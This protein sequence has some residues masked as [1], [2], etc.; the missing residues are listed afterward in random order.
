M[1]SGDWKGCCY[2]RSCPHRAQGGSSPHPPNHM[3]QEWGGPRGH[4]SGLAFVGSS[5]P[6]SPPTCDW[7]CSQAGTVL[8]GPRW[9]QPLQGSVLQTIALVK[10]A[11][12]PQRSPA[13]TGSQWASLGHTAFPNLIWNWGWSC[14]SRPRWALSGGGG[15]PRGKLRFSDRKGGRNGCW[16]GRDTDVRD[17]KEPPRM[18]AMAEAVTMPGTLPVSAAVATEEFAADAV[19]RESVQ[20]AAGAE[21]R[22]PCRPGGGPAQRRALHQHLRLPL[23]HAARPPPA[24]APPPAWRWPQ[25]HPCH[26][27][28]L[29]RE[30]M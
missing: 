6:L 26:R 27:Q 19:R 11:P 1:A 25:H 4:K 16:V 10:R 13:M 7:P 29:P 15:V 2:K 24:P 9:P 14:P 23:Q 28:Q 22:Q 30:E 21:L 8:R 5:S 17:G 3:D 20:R 18:A 12:C